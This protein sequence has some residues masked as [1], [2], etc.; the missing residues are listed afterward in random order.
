MTYSQGSIITGAEVMKD[1]VIVLSVVV[2]LFNEEGN[3]PR[4][5]DRIKNALDAVGEPYEIILVNDGSRDR[6]WDVITEMASA[7][8]HVKGVCLC[9]NFGHQNALLAGLSKA[10]GL[11]VISMD[12]DLQHPPELIP[13]LFEEWKKG[14]RIV[15]T[16]REDS[17]VTGFFKRLTSKYYYKFFAAMTDIPMS[18]GSSDFRLLDR[19][20]LDSLAEFRDVDLFLRGAINWIGY[21]AVIV[22]FKAEK[23]FSGNSKYS[24]KK[25]L[26]F[27]FGAIVSFSVKPLMLAVVI[28]MIT[29][30]LAFIEILYVL[31]QFFRGATVA[32]WTST[33]ALM[34]FLFGILFIILGI[35]GIYLSR[36]HQA[37]QN[38]PHFI[39][40][41]CVNIDIRK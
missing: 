12:G 15:N 3:I 8:Q 6:T 25:M 37:L 13:R 7:N 23:R 24:L 9:R 31:I 38:R 29:S 2:P 16:F 30:S 35:I 27:A 34:S 33:V 26:K 11:A 14:Y 22:P 20:V 10:S 17:E 41:D 5:V 4:L 18:A 21:P 19:Q 1:S 28:G 32:G 39:I 40:G 36:I